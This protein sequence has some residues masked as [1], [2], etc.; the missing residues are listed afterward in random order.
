MVGVIGVDE[1]EAGGKV[2]YAKGSYIFNDEEKESDVR[3]GMMKI[4]MPDFMVP[5]IQSTPQS[6]LIAQAVAVARQSDVVVACVGELNNMAGEGASRSDIGM[7]DAQS[8]LLKALKATGKPI[9]VVLTTG[10]PLI[11]NWEAKNADAILCTWG[12]GTEAGHA[13]A[14]VLFGDVN[15]SARLTTSFPRSVGQTMCANLVNLRS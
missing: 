15:P 8:D 10:R 9:V 11:L 12:L 13:V 14:D 3:Y 5:K 1:R 7:T 2:L 4:F 6:Q